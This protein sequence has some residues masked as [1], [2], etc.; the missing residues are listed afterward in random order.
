MK[1]EKIT[2]NKIRIILKQDDFKDK[3]INLQKFL[4]NSKNSQILLL[5]ILNKAEKDLKFQTNGYKLFIE[6][7]FEENNVCILTITKFI[8]QNNNLKIK[9]KIKLQKNHEHKENDFLIYEFDEFE[10]FCVFC[11]LIYKATENLNINII[12]NSFKNSQLYF[13]NNT[14]YL[15]LNKKNYKNL[16]LVKA[17]ILLRD[18]ATLKKYSKNFKSKLTE[19]GKLLIKSNAIYTG[20]KHFS[21]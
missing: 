10:N 4:L 14:Y 19:H 12:K 1:I 18:F 5:K 13:Y 17:I 3:N 11:N 21:N 8:D 9:K 7:F 16:I 20:I 2:K 15:V 6:S